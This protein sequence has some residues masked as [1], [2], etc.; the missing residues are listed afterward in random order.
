[1]RAKTA[2]SGDKIKGKGKSGKRDKGKGKNVQL[3][4]GVHGMDWKSEN[5]KRNK[6]SEKGRQKGFGKKGKV[7]LKGKEWRAPSPQRQPAFTSSQFDSKSTAPSLDSLRVRG[8][9]GGSFLEYGKFLFS[10]VLWNCGPSNS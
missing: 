10:L 2:E 9:Q 7:E 8:K 1:M 6:W 4:Q 5:V 3:D